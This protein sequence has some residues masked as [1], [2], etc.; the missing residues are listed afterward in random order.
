M[1]HRIL[2]APLDWGL[3]HTARCIPIIENHLREGNEIIFAGTKE[4]QEFI[5]Q[6]QLIIKCIDLFGYSIH[7]SSFLPQWIKISFQTPKIISAIK[8]EKKWLTKLLS[9]E[10][11]D[12]IISDN[13]Y[14]LFNKQAK[15][16]ILS[17]HLAP[18]SPIFSRF[19]HKKIASYINCFDECWIPDDEQLN[20]SGKLSFNKY[21]KIPTKKIGMISRFKTITEQVEKQYDVLILLSGIEPQRSLLE[22]K[23]L[24][25]L[26]KIDLKICLIRGTTEGKI[27]EDKITVYHRVNS[28]KLNQ[29]IHQSK[30]I[31]CRSG[32]T[33]IMEL[34]LLTNKII[35]I[36]T[37]GQTEQEYL[38]K[39][40]NEKFGIDYL[41][42][43]NIELINKMILKKLS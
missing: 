38:A 43:Q 19:I 40:M 17:H 35:L 11:F 26:K 7:Y 9:K 41:E 15:S 33:S 10:H 16:V 20:Y 4:Q 30:M 24:S 8:Q 37:P 6:H 28:E 32:Y 42:Q 36:P 21:V 1:A 12:L 14:G 3:G 18:E 34:L 23:L 27:I 25:E 22:R 31:I 5:A 13:R 2:I 29:L 39:N